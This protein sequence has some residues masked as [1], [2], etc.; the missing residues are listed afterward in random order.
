MYLSL[1]VG[2]S[3]HRML[4]MHT[5]IWIH[6][7]APFRWH[8][9]NTNISRFFARLYCVSVM[10][11]YWYIFIR[12]VHRSIIESFWKLTPTPHPHTYIHALVSNLHSRIQAPTVL[13]SNVFIYGS[14]YLPTCSRN[15]TVRCCTM[16]WPLKCGGRSRARVSSFSWSPNWVNILLHYFIFDFI[17]IIHCITT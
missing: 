4:M 5:L 14:I 10:K 9:T 17:Y 7:F 16:T 15:S 12:A 2:R 8:P 1:V 11:Y 13:H 3:V 6:I